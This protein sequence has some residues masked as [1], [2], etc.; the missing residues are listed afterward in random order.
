M[1]ISE[2]SNII[3][4]GSFD[5]NIGLVTRILKLLN[6]DIILNITNTS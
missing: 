1:K 6:E 5:V 4:W 2:S 3:I